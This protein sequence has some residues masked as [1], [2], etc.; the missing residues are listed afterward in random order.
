MSGTYSRLQCKE[1]RSLQDII[2]SLNGISGAE[3]VSTVHHT[4]SDGEVFLL[5]Y[6]K[7][8]FRVGG[9][10]SLTVQL[11]KQESLITADVIG[12]GGG[13]GIFNHSFGANR[14]FAKECIDI[15]Q[16]LGFR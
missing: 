4:F 11:A 13:G 6:E 16:A 8:Y 10:A 14:K 5:V 7:Y 15:L 12:S 2:R 9:Y 3:R 1:D